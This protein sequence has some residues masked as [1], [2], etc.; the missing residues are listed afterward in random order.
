[1]RARSHKDEV[2][3]SEEQRFVLQQL[4]SLGRKTGRTMSIS[5]Q[6]ARCG[7]CAFSVELSISKHVFQSIPCVKLP[8]SSQTGWRI[9]RVQHSSLDAMTP[10]R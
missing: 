8:S 6:N 4:L 3:L 7:T 1:M 10:L 2:A 5:S 9:S